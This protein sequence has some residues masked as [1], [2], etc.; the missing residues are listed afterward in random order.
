M[1]TNPPRAKNAPFLKVTPS[2]SR[3]GVTVNG[4][5]RLLDYSTVATLGFVSHCTCSLLYS[6]GTRLHVA[7]RPAAPATLHSCLVPRL[8]ICACVP[9]RPYALHTHGNEATSRPPTS[10]H[11]R[12]RC[13]AKTPRRMEAASLLF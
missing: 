11:V 3:C 2:R 12:A 9:Q 13:N 10:M 4:T 5:V 1:R 6:L 7:G 8:G